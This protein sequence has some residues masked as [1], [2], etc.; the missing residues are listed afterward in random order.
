MQKMVFNRRRYTTRIKKNHQTNSVPLSLREKE[1]R[2]RKAHTHTDTH[3]DTHTRDT[4]HTPR[5]E[6]FRPTFVD[7]RWDCSHRQIR[8]HFPSLCAPQ[9]N[10]CW[11]Q[12]S[13]F[14]KPTPGSFPPV[15]ILLDRG[16]GRSDRKIILVR[17]RQPL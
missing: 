17:P 6:C 1:Y 10:R 12:C 7:D 4:T 9:F 14:D 3:T 8:Q 13:L 15:P 16:A 11:Q 5:Q 2:Q